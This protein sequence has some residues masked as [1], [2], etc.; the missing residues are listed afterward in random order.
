[1]LVGVFTALAANADLYVVGPGTTAGWTPKDAIHISE[2]EIVDGY[3]TFTLNK[4]DVF[5]ISSTPASDPND[6]NGWEWLHIYF[7]YIKDRNKIQS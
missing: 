1:M 5:E 7:H 2:S 4:N 3:Y 6:N